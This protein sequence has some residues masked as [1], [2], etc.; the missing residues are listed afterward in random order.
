M[1]VEGEV[2][3]VHLAAGLHRQSLGV[4]DAAVWVD[5]DE[6]GNKRMFNEEKCRRVMFVSLKPKKNLIKCE[7]N[8]VPRKSRPKASATYML[9]TFRLSS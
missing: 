7:G 5:A 8:H 2:V 4:L 3:Q 6:S 1:L 9:G